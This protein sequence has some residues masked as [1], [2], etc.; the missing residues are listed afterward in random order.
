VDGPLS[1]WVD[2]AHDQL[3]DAYAAIRSVLGLSFLFMVL[4]AHAALVS[5]INYQGYLTDPNGQPLDGSVSIVPSILDQPTSPPGS[6][7]YQENH[8]NVLVMAGIFDLVIGAGQG[9]IGS[10]DETLFNTDRWL[11]LTVNRELLSPA[12]PFRYV[13]LYLH[14][15]V[16]DTCRDG[17]RGCSAGQYG[18][19]AGEIVPV[20]EACDGQ[21]HDCDG[22]ADNGAPGAAGCITP[23]G[24]VT[25]LRIWS[26][27]S[28]RIL[29]AVR[30]LHG[31]VRS[32]RTDGWGAFLRAV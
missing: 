30:L 23:T 1:A 10:F 12:Q 8:P 16:W 14:S 7:L 25:G 11:S 5:G 26:S 15:K 18:T 32:S 13:A 6:V 29:R 4:P 20:A 28:S 27:F 21:D 3:V 17:E 22:L 24:I 9:A 2:A 19:C 31:P